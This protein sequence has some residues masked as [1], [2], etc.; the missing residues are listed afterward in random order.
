MSSKK[1]LVLGITHLSIAMLGASLLIANPVS[2]DGGTSDSDYKTG[3][4]EGQ[5]VGYHDGLY[6]YDYSQY[7]SPSQTHPGNEDYAKGYG[8]GFQQGYNEAKSHYNNKSIFGKI[9][10]WLTYLFVTR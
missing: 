5:K 8:A 3:F 2:A 10:Y 9:W 6:P 7:Q 4:T 1:K